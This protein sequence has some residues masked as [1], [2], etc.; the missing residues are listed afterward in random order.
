MWLRTKATSSYFVSGSSSEL[1]SAAYPRSFLS[2]LS[3]GRPISRPFF[4]TFSWSASLTKYGNKKLLSE[5][6]TK[7]KELVG[8]LT[9]F[10]KN[11]QSLS[12]FLHRPGK[13]FSTSGLS[14]SIIHFYFASYLL[15]LIYIFLLRKSNKLNAIHVENKN[16]VRKEEIKTVNLNVKKTAK[17]I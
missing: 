14:N 9:T 15:L 6:Y 5:F 12:S 16:T 1:S 17:K 8:Q 13:S 10:R 3:L 11:S 2:F 4:A 7:K